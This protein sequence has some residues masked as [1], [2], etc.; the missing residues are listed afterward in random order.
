MISQL[1]IPKSNIIIPPPLVAVRQFPTDNFR[2]LPS[3]NFRNFPNDGEAEEP[4]PPQPPIFETFSSNTTGGSLLTIGAPSGLQDD[5]L[6]LGLWCFD[7]A[8]TITGTPSGWTELYS[9]SGS[10]PC[11][12]GWKIASSESGS[13][14]VN[15]NTGQGTAG[16][17]HRI[18]N[19]NTVTPINQKS[20]ATLNP[21]QTIDCPSITP[22]D[23]PTLLMALLYYDLTG[24]TIVSIYPTEMDS[25][26]NVRGGGSGGVGTGAAQE[27]KFDLGATGIRKW[28]LDNSE[29][30]RGFLIAVSAP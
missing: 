3:D 15:I 6:M 16:A 2:S 10:R 19:V 8:A 23:D 29:A 20:H 26:H 22:T 9:F 12:L 27:D 28:T 21:S 13:Y 24:A 25:I 1:I 4:Q 18:S 17:I 7:G 14:T 30:I 5:N 11:W